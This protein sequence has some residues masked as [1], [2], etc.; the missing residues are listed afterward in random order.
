MIPH[1]LEPH[2]C[3]VAL[4]VLGIVA[5]QVQCAARGLAFMYQHG[6]IACITSV[7]KRLDVCVVV[8]CVHVLFFFLLALLGVVAPPV[9]CC[10]SRD[11]FFFSVNLSLVAEAASWHSCTSGSAL[12]L[13][14]CA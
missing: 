1:Y 6:D 14:M 4:H 7:L 10:G 9:G 8:T 13:V 12:V 2:A 3:K 11:T 5:Y